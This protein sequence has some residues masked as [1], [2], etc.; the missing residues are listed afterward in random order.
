ME[1]VKRRIEPFVQLSDRS[2][3]PPALNLIRKDTLVG[4]SNIVTYLH[5]IQSQAIHNQSDA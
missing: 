1:L 4:Y 3:F 2:E 5:S